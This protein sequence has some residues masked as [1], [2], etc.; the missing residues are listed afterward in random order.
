MERSGGKDPVRVVLVVYFLCFLARLVEY[1]CIRT[2]QTA[3]GEAFLH[4]AVGVA[5]LLGTLRALGWRPGEIGFQRRTAA[6]QLL[7]G[8]LLGGGAF[9]AGYGTELLALSMGGQGPALRFYISSFSPSG[10][11]VMETSALFFLICVAGNVLNVVMEEGV[12]RGLFLRLFQERMPFARAALA[13]SLLFGAW[14]IA[15]PL[16][17]LI[18]GR[19]GWGTALAAALAQLVLTGLMGVQLCLLVRLSGG[20]W[21]SMAVHFVNNFLVNILHTVTASGTDEL[22]VLRISVA[23]TVSFLAV[24]LALW[25][26]RRRGEQ[27]R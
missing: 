14:H 6:R 19:M 26:R 22:Q 18:D 10:N 8:A 5:L 1:L 4:K 13:A 3:I 15:S 21:M 16:R 20:L 12:F 24:L 23:Q 17:E 25:R 2:D 11:Q 7:F 27:A 9:L